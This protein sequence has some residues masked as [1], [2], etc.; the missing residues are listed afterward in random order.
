MKFQPGSY[1][2]YEVMHNQGE[3]HDQL[4]ARFLIDDNAFHILE[5]YNHLLSDALPEGLFD[6]GHERMLS[7][8]ASSGYYKIIHEDEANQGH[9]EN[10]IEDLDIGDVEP[11]S[12]YIIHEEGEEPQTM[13]MYGEIAIL[14][15]RKLTDE[16]LQQIMDKVKS[17]ELSM[18]PF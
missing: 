12:E 11:D 9:H 3:P 1:R 5:D 8:L 15:G 10:L 13:Q 7:Q 16:E 4:I 18:H 14:N 17:G 6:D 2:I